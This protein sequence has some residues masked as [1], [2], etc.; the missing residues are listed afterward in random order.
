VPRHRR[1]HVP[2]TRWSGAFAKYDAAPAGSNKTS[3]ILC[4]LISTEGAAGIG[5]PDSRKAVDSFWPRAGLQALA[6]R[7]RR[8]QPRR[9]PA[10]T[11][12]GSPAPTL[13]MG[14]AAVRRGSPIVSA[15]LICV[16]G[17]GCGGFD[18]KRMARRDSAVARG[19][20]NQAWGPPSRG[21][22]RSRPAYIA[23]QTNTQ[24]TNGP[25]F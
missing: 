19:A 7:R 8:H 24:M 22:I 13:G 15:A 1:R 11:R 18:A 5:R 4:R 16:G 3:Y 2:R 6:A 23:D 25:T 12:P 14:T 21:N 10:K 9:P 17:R 20:L